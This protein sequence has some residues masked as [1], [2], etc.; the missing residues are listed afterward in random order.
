MGQP[1]ATSNQIYIMDKQ[2]Q[3]PQEQEQP[4]RT[5]STEQMD[6]MVKLKNSGLTHQDVKYGFEQI[7]CLNSKHSVSEL[8]YNELNVSSSSSPIT[9]SQNHSPDVAPER[10]DKL[11]RQII[12][13]AQITRGKVKSQQKVKKVA[14][15]TL[16]TTTTP[17]KI[18]EKA[19]TAAKSP[20]EIISAIRTQKAAKSSVKRLPKR[21]TRNRTVALKALKVTHDQKEEGAT[22]EAAS[23]QSVKLV[24]SEDVKKVKQN[25]K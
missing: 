24:F 5:F 6:L 11:R 9:S 7:E 4:S 18:P 13:P 2:P 12:T 16:E 22:A 14:A 1:T 21:I 3:E 15:E 8:M 20:V 25:R 10:G 19:S 23:S 17:I